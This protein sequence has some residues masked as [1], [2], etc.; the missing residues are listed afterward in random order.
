MFGPFK[1][2]IEPYE[3]DLSN[4]SPKSGR[5]QRAEILAPGLV[6]LDAGQRAMHDLARG[7]DLL[8]GSLGY[9]RLESARL[10]E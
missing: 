3:R 8:A 9:R 10:F 2:G 6:L 4:L 7:L 5:T 1:R